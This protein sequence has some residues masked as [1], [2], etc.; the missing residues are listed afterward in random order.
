M[1]LI[2]DLCTTASCV[3]VCVCVCELIQLFLVSYPLWLLWVNNSLLVLEISLIPALKK[4][5]LCRIVLL[6]TRKEK[7]V[8]CE[9][10]LYEKPMSYVS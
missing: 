6:V 1:K 2:N 10:D 4:T 8:L 5:R 3:C 7:C 9:Y